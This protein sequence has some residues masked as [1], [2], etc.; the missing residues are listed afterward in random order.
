MKD[1]E[2]PRK[3]AVDRRALLANV[4]MD[5]IRGRIPKLPDP[6]PLVRCSGNI[7]GKTHT[8]VMY[9]P[10]GWSPDQRV[11]MVVGLHGGGGN[12]AAFAAQTA[13]PMV[14][15]REGFLLLFPEATLRYEDEEGI[16]HEWNAFYLNDPRE[17][18]TVWLKELIERVCGE[19]N[20]DRSRIYLFGHSNGDAM[21]CQ[22]AV[23]HAD[24]FAAYAGLNGPVHPNK[25]TDRSGAPIRPAV[26]LPY[27]RWHGE[28]DPLNGGAGIPRRQLNALINRYWIHHNRCNVQPQFRLDG[29]VGTAIFESECRAEVRFAEYKGGPHALNLEVAAVVWYEFFQKYARGEDGAIVR[30]PVSD[31][32][33]ADR[34]AVVLAD[35]RSL[36]MKNHERFAVDPQRP[37]V[38]LFSRADSLFVPARLFARLF[39][40]EVRIAAD[41]SRAEI[42]HRGRTAVVMEGN[43]VMWVDHRIV[44]FSV[45]PVRRSGD[46]WFSVREVAEQALGKH[47]SAFDGTVYIGDRPHELGAALAETMAASLASL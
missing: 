27:L 43:P 47:V 20:V 15:D 12:G 19:Y 5:A 21:A 36:V 38:R 16:H 14:A 29:K 4:D 8:W 22:L 2:Q 23:T 6:E 35:K 45:P 9:I 42:L 11:P 26:P 39:G 3:P 13:F 46:L 30:R 18:E 32:A 37:D 41:L 28:R 40:A 33:P 7:A 34:N 44:P 17:D 1:N 31:P 24:L 10:P 25:I